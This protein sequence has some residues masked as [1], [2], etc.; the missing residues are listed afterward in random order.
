MKYGKFKA[1]PKLQNL[2]SDARLNLASTNVLKFNLCQKLVY[3]GEQKWMMN[4]FDRPDGL[5]YNWH[6]LRNDPFVHLRRVHEY[7]IIT[8]RAGFNA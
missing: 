8:I 3:T 2:N 6:D 5:G 7:G 4:N 1:K